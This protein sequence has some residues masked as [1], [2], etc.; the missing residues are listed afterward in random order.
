MTF[1]SRSSCMFKQTPF[2]IYIYI[3]VIMSYRSYPQFGP[4]HISTFQF[5]DNF[6]LP[7]GS[8]VLVYMLTW[9]GYIDGIHV[10]IYSSTMD[11]SWVMKKIHG[12]IP[13]LRRWTVKK[14][15]TKATSGNGPCSYSR[16]FLRPVGSDVTN[17]RPMG[18]PLL[19]NGEA[20]ARWAFLVYTV[21]AMATSSNWW[22]RWDYTFP[23]CSMYGIFTYIY[24]TNGRV[25]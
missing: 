11:P 6:G 14:I 10:T 1:I 2:Y 24:P 22:F 21:M 18:C 16:R 3:W 15:I 23:I 9:L 8:M 4:I 7:I 19:S 17:S 5:L 20:M 12:E 13:V 25:L